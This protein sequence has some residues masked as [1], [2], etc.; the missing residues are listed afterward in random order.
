MSG[1]GLPDPLGPMGLYP[2]YDWSDGAGN[3]MP[4]DFDLDIRAFTLVRGGRRARGRAEWNYDV[5]LLYG[6]YAYF[7]ALT[8]RPEALQA[9]VSWAELIVDFQL[10]TC[11]AMPGHRTKI[12][13]FLVC[14]R[15]EVFYL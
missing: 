4:A 11:M 10:T 5:R 12:N 9:T 2:K 13:D 3:D 8:W 15:L 6:L 7:R 1:A 14:S